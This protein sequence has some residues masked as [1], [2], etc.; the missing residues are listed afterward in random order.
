MSRLIVISNRVSAPR[1]DDPK[2][3]QG[4]L[5][6]A[7][8]AALREYRGMW[9]GW[10]G[11]RT[12]TFTG[13][14]HFQRHEG[15]TTATIDLEEQDVDEYYNGYANR[16]LWPLFHYRVDLPNSTEA[17]EAATRGSTSALPKPSLR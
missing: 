3:A 16:T 15:V 6:V 2:G 1:A 10:S 8:A 4:G 17:S 7:L 5:S 12:E 13:D 14:I 11:N 9:F